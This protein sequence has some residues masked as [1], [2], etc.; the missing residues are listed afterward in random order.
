[1][2]W[3]DLTS[4]SLVAR[5]HPV[6]ATGLRCSVKRTATPPREHRWDKAGEDLLAC[7]TVDSQAP[8]C[9]PAHVRPCACHTNP[10]SANRLASRLID[11]WRPRDPSRRNLG[12]ASHW[13][14][15]HRAC[16]RAR[17]AASV[18]CGRPGWRFDGGG[19]DTEAELKSS[20][21]R[22]GSLLRS[23]GH[24]RTCPPCWWATAVEDRRCIRFD[25]CRASGQQ[26]LTVP[27]SHALN[28]WYDLN[29]SRGSCS[30]TYYGG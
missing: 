20:P 14:A 25:F 6:F 12:R 28:R 11:Q 7:T 26:N 8:I 30:R 21:L 18:G 16:D 19:R 2:W 24:G 15:V 22:M 13:P 17:S 29:R 27:S 23:A 3:L 4:A 10:F 5:T 9:S 1:M